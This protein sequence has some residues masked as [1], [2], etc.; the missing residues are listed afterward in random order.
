M[1]T[2]R[3]LQ[4][5]Y[6]RQQDYL[7][8][9]QDELNIMA[10]SLFAKLNHDMVLRGCEVVNNGNGTINIAPGIVYV[11]G[12]VMRFDGAS[13]I[14]ADGTKVLEKGV[15]TT[16]DP[17]LF[18][19]GQSKNV[20]TETKAV[21]GNYASIAQIKVLPNL[22]TLASYIEDV[23]ASYAVKGEI[24]DI[25]DFDGTFL[26][27]FDESGLGI[28]ARYSNWALFNGN[29]G[30]PNGQGRMRLTVG[31][32]TNPLTGL[33]TAFAHGA[34]GGETVHKLTVAEMPKHSHPYIKPKG[35][36]SATGNANSHP[37]GP[38]Q[39]SNTGEVGGD[40]AHNNMPPYIAVYTI[41]KIA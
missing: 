26:N 21:I 8:T 7:L 13:N 12:E 2:L 31:T 1:K 35:E 36:G 25:Y 5:G 15:P 11:S 39:T 30:T 20:Y 10:N 16:S 32:V 4:G 6:P 29:N 3:N 33:Q 38:L 37:D 28:T 41:I 24:K 34:A 22:Y 17:K 19:D 14:T 9:L 23:A 18:A 40:E 27:N